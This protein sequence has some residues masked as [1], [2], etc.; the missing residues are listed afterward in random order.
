MS[1]VQTLVTTFLPRRWSASI[2]A[3]SRQ[4]MAH[5]PCGHAR[6]IWDL[7][8]IRW[9]AAGHPR[10]LLNCPECGQNTWHTL[11]REH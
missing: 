1:L 5:C 10:R 3:E 6:S 4:W 7:G 11:T 9:K 2:E 8:G